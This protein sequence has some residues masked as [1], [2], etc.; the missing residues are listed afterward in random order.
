MNVAD[1]RTGQMAIVDQVLS[2]GREQGI[3]QRLAAMGV[4]SDKPVQVLR[5]AGFNGPLHIRVGATTEIA[6]RSHEAEMIVIKTDEDDEINYYQGSQIV[7]NSIIELISQVKTISFLILIS[8]IFLV[9]G[10]LYQLLNNSNIEQANQPQNAA[11]I[12]AN[13]TT[14]LTENPTLETV[15]VDKVAPTIAPANN[16]S[17]SPET[18]TKAPTENTSNQLTITTNSSSESVE[19]IGKKITDKQE[20]SRLQEKLYTNIDN[21]WKKPVKQTAIYIVKVDKNGTII[22][23]EAFNEIAKNHLSSTPLPNLVKPNN[24]TNQTEWTEFAILLYEDGNLEIE[25]K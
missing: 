18:T 5:K 24:F 23:Y 22:S 7:P 4:I 17:T 20:I 2:I 11:N 13:S 10:Q 12:V 16:E 6:I 1:L 8:I 19:S 14:E 15:V 9:I 3:V 25:P 21:N